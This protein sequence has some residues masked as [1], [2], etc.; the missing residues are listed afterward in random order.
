MPVVVPQA[1]VVWRAALYRSGIN[2]S[3][4]GMWSRPG[5]SFSGAATEE[6]Q[7]TA[8]GY[9]GQRIALNDA[10]AYRAVRAETIR[11]RPDRWPPLIIARLFW[12]V[13][14][15]IAK[16]GNQAIHPGDV[17]PT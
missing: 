13:G 7:H 16:P 17:C 14:R 9:L 8:D 1:T 3:H 4:F 6:L 5:Q 10:Y 15:C 11:R 12:G 2:R